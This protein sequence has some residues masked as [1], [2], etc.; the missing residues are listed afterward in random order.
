M[1]KDDRAVEMRPV[2]VDRQ[3]GDQM[4]IASGISAGETVVTDGHRRLT[5]GSRVVE[6]SNAA[7]E[8]GQTGTRAGRGAQ[9]SR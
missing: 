8:R 1:V 2:K 7:A 5:P 6:R 4:V 9:G 3:Q